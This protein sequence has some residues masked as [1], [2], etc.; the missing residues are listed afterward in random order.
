MHVHANHIYV[1]NAVFGWNSQPC[2][3][4][5]PQLLLCWSKSM[6]H[7]QQQAQAVHALCMLLGIEADSVAGTI[8]SA[9]RAACNASDISVQ[10]ACTT[11]IARG[12]GRTYAYHLLWPFKGC[13]NQT[14][15]KKCRAAR[16]RS[17]CG[18]INETNCCLG[19]GVPNDAQRK[20]VVPAT[21]AAQLVSRNSKATRRPAGV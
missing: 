4:E 19:T 20:M 8:T 13:A 16:V 3:F 15:L 7:L 21:V 12:T 10:G 18:N 11:S 14:A 17:L 1:D 6:R 5:G 9:L 2:K